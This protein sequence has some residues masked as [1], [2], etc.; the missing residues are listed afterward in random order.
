MSSVGLIEYQHANRRQR[1]RTLLQQFQDA[2]GRADDEVWLMRQRSEVW[3]QRDSAAQ[4]QHFDVGDESG[5]P[6]DLLADLV[7]EFAC[8]AQHQSLQLD[9]GRIDGSQ[10]TE[11]KCRRLAAAGLGLGDH[12]TSG[13]DRWQARCLH[14][15]HLQVFGG[16][17]ALMQGCA[18]G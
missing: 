11:R 3:T 2:T 9:T 12:I 8:R 7:G 14:R 17:Y 6:P 5:E 15:R 18:Q 13:E 16:S 4:G 1:Q 10:Q